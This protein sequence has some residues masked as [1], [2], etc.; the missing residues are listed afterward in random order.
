MH[1]MMVA[2]IGA[3]LVGPLQAHLAELLAAAPIPEALV[4]DALACVSRAGP[5]IAERFADDP[6]WAALAGVRVWLGFADPIA[7]LAEAAPGCAPALR[8]AGTLIA[9]ASS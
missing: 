8:S 5:V 4:R 7:L 2:V 1:E 3:L 9:S 6:W